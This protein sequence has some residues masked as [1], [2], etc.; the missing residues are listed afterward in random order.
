MAYDNSYDYDLAAKKRRALA[1]HSRDTA[2]G[3]QVE[4]QQAAKRAA[5][6]NDRNAMYVVNRL[7][8]LDSQAAYLQTKRDLGLSVHADISASDE[9]DDGATLDELKAKYLPVSH[10]E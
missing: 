10:G 6:I 1:D 2:E 9:E 3:R 8:G 4:Q 5:D 7:N